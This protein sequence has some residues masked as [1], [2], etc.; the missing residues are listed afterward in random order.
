MKRIIAGIMTVALMGLLLW[1]GRGRTSGGTGA[2]EATGAGIVADP[3]AVNAV[4]NEPDPAELR[5]NALLEGAWRGDV[6]GYLDCFGGPLRDRLGREVEERGRD[7]FAEDLRRSARSR[8]SHAVF[9]VEPEGEDAARITVETVYPDRNERQTY[10]L[11]RD[12]AA[13]RWLVVDVENAR[14]RVPRAKFGAAATFR[15]PEGVPVQ[16]V[17]LRVETDADA[18]DTGGEGSGTAAPRP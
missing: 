3:G 12:P 18:D 1:N 2:P 7:A 11:A 16:G 10:H 15:E 9:G 14:G 8:K 17:P 4:A 13:G 6:A 5:L